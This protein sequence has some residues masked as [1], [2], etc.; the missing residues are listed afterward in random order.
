MGERAGIAPGFYAHKFVYDAQ[1]DTVTCPAGHRMALRTGPPNR[2]ANGPR[3][4]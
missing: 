4:W 3:A 1:S 2:G